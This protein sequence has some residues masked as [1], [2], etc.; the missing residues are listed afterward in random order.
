MEFTLNTSV[1]KEGLDLAIINANVSKF[2][3]KSCIVE[4]NIEDSTLRVNT[5]ASSIKSELQ[6]KGRV[7]GDGATHTFVDSLLL[8]NLVNT[9][10]S[11]TVM[12]S[13]NADGLVVQSGKA[14]FNLPQVVS[15]DDIELSRPENVQD[16]VSTVIGVNNEA[17]SFIKDQ[18]LYAIAMSFVHPVYRNIW[19]S[20]IGDVLVGDFDN[21][22][23]THSTKAQLSTTCLIPDTI[24]NLLTAVPEDSQ[25]IQLGRNYEVRVESNPYT[26]VCEFAPKYEDNEDVGN[27]SANL[28]LQLFDTDSESISLDAAII[29]KYI[30]QAELF[31]STSDDT[32][33][34]C[35]SDGVFKLHNKN[36]DCRIPVSE[37][38]YPF[39][40]VFKIDLLKDMISHMDAEVIKVTPLI[41]NNEAAGIVASTDN[42]EAIL[43]GIE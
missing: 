5:E 27:Y 8:K 20:D 26:Y 39:E 32:I 9:L 23:F 42:M 30:S 24:V 18:Q 38:V 4:L 40:V 1:L 36:V 37:D 29:S 22:I 2:Y 34:M 11:D 25:I 41:Q 14:K 21:S 7:D 16:D 19:M 28:I 35:V 15:V 10:D 17:W 33:T 43:A 31:A 12:L 6:F 13:I 3:Q